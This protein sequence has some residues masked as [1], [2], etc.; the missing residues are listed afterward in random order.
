MLS[1]LTALFTT[2][3]GIDVLEERVF[4]SYYLALYPVAT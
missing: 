1:P 2:D 3:C 4:S